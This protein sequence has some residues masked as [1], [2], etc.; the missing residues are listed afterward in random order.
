MTKAIEVVENNNQNIILGT[1]SAGNE[2][3]NKK[4]YEGENHA[5]P[6]PIQGKDNSVPATH[7]LIPACKASL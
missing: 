7:S 6:A 5:Y 3:F 2:V 1:G 4:N